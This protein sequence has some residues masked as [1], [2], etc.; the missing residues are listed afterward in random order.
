[1]SAQLK[2]LN[3]QP[4]MPRDWLKRRLGRMVNKGQKGGPFRPVVTLSDVAHWFVVDVTL[5]YQMERG[6]LEITDKWQ[7]QFSQFFYLL[8]T[9]QI[10]IVVDMKRRKK[11]WRRATPAEPP[12]KAPMPRIDFAATKLRF[13]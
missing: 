5:I 9:G 10:E 2:T 4:L 6:T 7:V 8:D 11:T 12:C 13:D 3:E 1:M